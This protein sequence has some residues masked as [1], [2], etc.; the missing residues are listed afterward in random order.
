MAASILV[1]EHDEQVRVALRD[2]LERCGYDV[3]EAADGNEAITAL[4]MAPFD[5][6][7]AAITVP[8]KDGIEIMG[9]VRKQ[10]PGMPVVIIGGPTDQ[11]YLDS[12]REL[13]AACTFSKPVRP[14][15]L[16]SA[17]RQLLVEHKS[18]RST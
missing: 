13:G 5:L 2:E 9:Y 3:C 14:D 18:E 15:Q 1:A 11:L 6:V 12:A 16:A 10:H 7:V 17:V 4:Q 8:G